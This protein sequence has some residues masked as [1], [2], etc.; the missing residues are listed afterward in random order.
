MLVDGASVVLMGSVASILGN[1][2]FIVYSASKAAIRNFA[3]SWIQD[4]APRRIRVNVVA[5]GAVPT[6]GSVAL[7]GAEERHREISAV[8]AAQV[9]LGRLGTEDEVAAAALFLA[10]DESSYTNGSEP[11]VDGGRGQV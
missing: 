6:A 5:P 7:F 11:Y 9:P 3:R 2:A 8:M 10:S 4:L 1:R